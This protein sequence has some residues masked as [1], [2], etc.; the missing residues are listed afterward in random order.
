MGL[1][2]SCNEKYFEKIDTE[3]KAYWLGFIY[4]DGCVRNDKS[5]LAIVLS[6]K[7]NELLETF[8]KCIDSNYQIKNI[9]RG[10]FDYI[11]LRINSRKLCKDLIDKGCYPQKT[12]ILK[13]PTQEQVPSHLINHFIRG[14]F[15][16]DGCI[17][18]NLCK[19]NNRPS[20]FMRTEINFLGT[21]ELLEGIL[22]YIP[23]SNAKISKKKTDNI[24][25]LR[26][27]NKKEIILVMDYIYENATIFLHRKYEKYIRNIKYY[28]KVS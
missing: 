22:H 16:G 19:V 6:K 2:Y 9:N 11:D 13:F 20:L 15:D 12:F 7:D 8:N 10:N 1:K 14:Y 3:D 18:A 4:A 21:K 23:S 25:A 26:I 27:Y 28:V 24:Y 5:V 17:Y